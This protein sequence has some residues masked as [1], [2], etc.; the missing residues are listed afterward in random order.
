MLRDINQAE[1]YDAIPLLYETRGS[2]TDRNRVEGW[3]PGPWA[4]GVRG[5]AS[6]RAASSTQP[7]DGSQQHCIRCLNAARNVDRTC[8]HHRQEMVLT[9]PSVPK[10]LGFKP[11]GIPG[12]GPGS[13]LQYSHLWAT[14]CGLG[15]TG[16]RRVGSARTQPPVVIASQYVSASSHRT[17]T[18][19]VTPRYT[20]L[21]SQYIKLW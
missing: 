5:D 12:G 14:V 19:K 7:G 20:S 18:W 10:R 21:L 15:S 9:H 16:S 4:G 1:K 2:G 6:P 13:T 17:V 11:W 8:P 3:W